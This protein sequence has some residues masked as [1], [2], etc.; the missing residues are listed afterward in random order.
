MNPMQGLAPIG[1]SRA[2]GTDPIPP[3]EAQRLRT[4]AAE[5][6]SLLLSQMLKEMRSSMLGDDRESGFGSNPLTD[7]VFSE[8]S[9]ALSRAGGIGIADAIM[10]P[11]SRQQ[12]GTIEA[13]PR[14]EMPS[15]V[16]RLAAPDVHE[17][18]DLPAAPLNL[19]RQFGGRVSSAYGWRQ[20]PINGQ[21]RFHAGT[22]IALPVGQHVPA[23]RAGRVAFAGEM[24]GYGL[25]VLV[26]HDGQMA[27]RYAH[28][29]RIDV[30]EG[31][32]VATG[33]T[34]ARSGATGRVT[35]PH[36]HFEV[37]ESGRPVDPQE[38]FGPDPAPFGQ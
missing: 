24:P 31:Q 29:S 17:P 27:T 13:K 10:E 32:S 26:E 8:L 18:A 15:H 7:S 33:Q 11:L 12:A 21:S 2:A 35:G 6:E 20:D 34:I 23:A 4:L 19:G 22:D 38:L 3:A 36:L 9:L 25:T 30:Q 16:P 37:L 5:F 28:L 14:L 1:A